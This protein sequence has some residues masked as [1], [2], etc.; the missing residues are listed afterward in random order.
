M[1][2]IMLKIKF[3]LLNGNSIM[4]LSTSI[5]HAEHSQNLLEVELIAM[6]SC[7]LWSIIYNEYLFSHLFGIEK[8]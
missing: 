4:F 8:L 7:L 6:A 3:S 2:Y 1:N 5:Q